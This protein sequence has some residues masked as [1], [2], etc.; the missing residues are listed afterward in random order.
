VRMIQV[1][2]SNMFCHLDFHKCLVSECCW[3]KDPGFPCTHSINVTFKN[4]IP[5]VGSMAANKK[6]NRMVGLLFAAT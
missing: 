1:I 2:G 6:A 5:K 3:K 4:D